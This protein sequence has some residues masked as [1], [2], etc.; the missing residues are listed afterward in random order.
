MLRSRYPIAPFIHMTDLLTFND[1]YERVSGWNEE[2]ISSLVLDALQIL[3]AMDK[4]KFCSFICTV[5]V[6]ARDRLVAEGV[7]VPHPASICAT[8]CI[9]QAMQ[10][11]IANHFDDGT[12]E[13]IHIFFDRNERFITPIRDIHKKHGAAEGRVAPNAWGLLSHPQ[14][15]DMRDHPPVQ[16]ADMLAWGRS[17][18]L[19]NV[20]Q[21][22]RYLLEI[23]RGIIPSW[24]FNI[25]EKVM[26]AKRPKVG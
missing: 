4:R 11:Y 9:R 2:K 20:E 10:W 19:S 6:S 16:A 25:D 17:R 7:P 26:R 15:V 23:M 24:T 5:D 22:F 3:Q 12:L 8:T 13:R 18:E 14:D 1:P 21:P